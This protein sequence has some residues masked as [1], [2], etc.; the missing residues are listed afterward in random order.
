[1][2]AFDRQ[3]YWTARY[4]KYNA[5]TFDWY[6]T[7]TQLRVIILKDVLFIYPLL[8][9]CVS[10]QHQQNLI[11]EDSQYVEVL[12][13]GCGNSALLEQMYD[14]DRFKK[15][16][17]IDLCK[18]VI[19]QMTERNAKVRPELKFREMDCLRLDFAERSFD[20][21]IDKATLDT[22]LCGENPYLTVARYLKEVQRV[23]RV[24]GKFLLIST[25]DKAKRMMHLKRSH[26]KFEVEVVEVK[27]Q[28]DDC[29]VT[30]Y[31]FICTKEGGSDTAA[32]NWREEKL[33]IYA[34]EGFD[35]DYED[36]FSQEADDQ[37]K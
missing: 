35:S 9:N 34:E 37:N 12:D 7:Y 11:Y 6:E 36:G 33:K 18:V 16:I 14:R 28:T 27:R 2:E 1:M 22:L 19:E 20:L 25:G 13:V 5:T 15:L 4:E 32:Y 10:E 26:L 30:H 17:G 21:V 8:A 29:E 3:D 24:G 31:L 23:L